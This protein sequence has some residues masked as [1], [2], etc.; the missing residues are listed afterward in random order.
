MKD[1]KTRITENM[2]SLTKSQRTV[3]DYILRH[4]DNIPFYT[5][6][7]LSKETNVSTATIIRFA[8]SVGCESYSEMQE[9]LQDELRRK[10]SLPGRLDS[11]HELP[12][13]ELLSTI[14]QNDIR[15]IE[16]LA[17]Q[18]TD[19]LLNSVVAALDGART[20]YALGMRT[21]FS[22]ACYSEVCLGQI[23]GNVRLVHTTGMI[24]PEELLSAGEGDVCLA[25]L[26]PRYARISIQI[27]QWMR[28]Q[29]VRIILVTSTSSSSVADLGDLVIPCPITGV[30]LKNSYAA[31]VSVI[32]YLFAALVTR[33]RSRTSQMLSQAEALLHNTLGVN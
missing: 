7:K 5:L 20:V 10:A 19:E 14:L 23:L 22:L 15:N 24:C 26:F 9:L 1:L 31:P 30:S 25:F 32:N 28:T 33:N 3:A 2:N 13:D 21:S 4:L 27:L 17:A 11:L 8:R 16:A 12:K 18:L 29:K 6:E